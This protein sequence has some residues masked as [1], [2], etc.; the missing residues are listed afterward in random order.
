[1]L[2]NGYSLVRMEV[3]N[4]GNFHGYQK[5][6]LRPS[7]DDGALFAP[8]SA[9]AILGVNGSGKSTLI[10]AL[11]ITLLPFEGSVKLGVT[12]DVET[13]SSGGRTIR[14]YILGKHS[15]TTGRE[16]TLAA[17]VGRKDGCSLVVLV[18]RH[19]RIPD[20]QITVGR[21]WWYQNFT[22]SETQLAFVAYDAISISQLC[23][24]GVTPRSAKVFRQHCKDQLPH[25][26]VFETLQAYFAALSGSFGKISKDDL[27]IL[28]RAFYVK[29]I[30]QIDS[31]IRENM[32]LEQESPNLERLLENVRNGQ[33]IAYSIETCQS[34]I[35][36]IERILKDLRKL[37]KIAEGKLAV[38]RKENLLSLHQEWS[39]LQRNKSELIKLKE[40]M[41][42][43][44]DELPRMERAIQEARRMHVAIQ[45][46]IVHND[47][48][49][50]IAKLGV[51]SDFLK[52]RLAKNEKELAEVAIDA[53][54]FA[55][56]LPKKDETWARLRSEI[57]EGIEL[58]TERARKL[59][60]Q[61]EGL[62][63]RKFDLDREG[64]EVRDELEHLSKNKT[65]IPRELFAIKEDAIRELKIPAGRIVFVGELVQVKSECQ[66]FRR[67]VE[68]VLFPISRNLLCHPDHLDDLTKWLE[69]KGLRTD[70]VAKRITDVELSD[71]EGAWAGSGRR[72]APAREAGSGRRGSGRFANTMTAQLQSRAASYN[73][74]SEGKFVLDMIEIL[75]ER[76]H[77]FTRYIWQ[78]LRAKFDYRVV[79]VKELR[80]GDG[81]LVTL[82]GLVKSDRRTMRKLKQGFQYSLGWD[83]R[84]RIEELVGR[85]T[86]VNAQHARASAELQDLEA[87][88]TFEEDRCR[89]MSGL[90]DRSLELE[91]VEPDRARVVALAKEIDALERDNPDY[92]QLKKDEAALRDQLRTL[93]KK[94]NRLESDIENSEKRVRAIEPLLPAKEKEIKESLIYGE[95][96][97]SL[98]G[99]T[100]LL[101]AL[102]AIER[103]L[104]DSKR[105][106]L[107]M[108]AELKEKSASLE[109]SADHARSAVSAA[110]NGYKRDFNDPSLSYVVPENALVNGFVEEWSGAEI[111]LRKTELPQAQEKWKRFFDQ[112]LMDSIKDTINEIKSKLNDIERTI[113]SI[114]DVLKLTN[115]EDLPDDQRYLKINAERSADDRIRKFRKSITEIE[116]IL[117]PGYRS[118][119]EAL[120]Q[121]IMGVLV[122][123]VDEFQKETAYRNYVTDV[124]NHFQFEVHSLRRTEGGVDELVEVFTGARRDA[125]SSAQTTQLAYALLASCLA[126][127][128]KFHDP[129]GSQ[130]TLRLIVLDEFGGKFDNEK[131]REILKLLDKMGFQSI[132]V[133]PMSKADLLAEGISHLVFVHKVSATHSKVQSHEISS[134]A[135]YDKLVRQMAGVTA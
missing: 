9:S 55:V 51:E 81:E 59:R 122:P 16:G 17:S 91:T 92:K 14:D 52:E 96:R 5:F 116:K 56:K 98:G 6:D 41:E 48:D 30:S 61:L 24:E 112:I 89:F 86:E 93:E 120:S 102:D 90:R 49:S 118:Q 75:P 131:P 105:T 27:K 115:F 78:W 1:M 94:Q 39:E 117:G 69:K 113:L 4:W 28:N 106:R 109:R 95:L 26:Q 34:K 119:A 32:L 76:Q 18:F 123:F 12:N 99:E 15:A 104:R 20:R 62:R 47:V 19:N 45:S 129:I 85:L 7:K 127:R 42:A 126:Y 60:E 57:G 23:I 128:F 108:A 134:K 63:E 84:E 88:I 35:A 2:D 101:E 77:P 124:R 22:V 58:A 121:D 50:R 110:L 100:A 107:Q 79:D 13:G 111:R 83:N 10:D 33:E 74:E 46:Q 21:I 133:S 67:A 82:E 65:L 40:E 135:D 3:Y 66:T 8:P 97:L 114:N 43:G 132:L 130:E 125:K 38:D 80:S 11:M 54:K 36:L 29:S 44:R 72:L 25:L 103:E 64:R 70:L 31:F 71:D 37:E 87:R 73:E 68:S 53:K